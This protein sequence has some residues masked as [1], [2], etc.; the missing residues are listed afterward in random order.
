MRL[1][2]LFGTAILVTGLGVYALAAVA[3]ATRLLP[4]QWAVEAGFYAL[5]G[6][7][8]IFPAAKL[9]RWMQQAAPFRPPP[10]G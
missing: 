9:T 4:D 3:V 1:R 6:I 5:V 8:W 2:I 10:F 7:I